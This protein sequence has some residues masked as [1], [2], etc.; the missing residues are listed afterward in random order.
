MWFIPEIESD[1]VPFH[2]LLPGSSSGRLGPELGRGRESYF[3]FDFPEAVG[4]KILPS[5]GK[6]T[7]LVFS[8]TGWSFVFL[9]NF[10]FT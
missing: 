4:G 9:K 5:L 8:D 3:P 6:G 10:S 1:S 7:V 2:G